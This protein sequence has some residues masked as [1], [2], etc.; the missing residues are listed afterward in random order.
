V[1]EQKLCQRDKMLGWADIMTGHTLPAWNELPDLELYMDQVVSLVSNYLSHLGLMLG[2]DKPVT[3]AMINNYVKMGIMRAPVKKRYTRVHLASLIMICIL[4]RSLNMSA[5]Q[6][7]IPRD[8]TD[9]EVRQ[10]YED[11][12]ASRSGSIDF[13][14]NLVRTGD[15]SLFPADDKS[16]GREVVIRLAVMA[17]L[18]KLG[19][20]KLV[21]ATEG[22]QK[23]KKEKNTKEKA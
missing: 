8:M 9:E 10:M 17:N 2:E 14:A 5:I 16:D 19:A 18:L 21:G 6:K 3:P 22:D 15:E 11:F 12:R 4:K 13:L 7:L 1:E 23:A 20:E